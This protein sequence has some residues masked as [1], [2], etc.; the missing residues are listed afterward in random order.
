[1]NKLSRICFSVFALFLLSAGAFAQV[2]N[3]DS[4]TPKIQTNYDQGK[5][6][7]AVELR[8]L[9][10]DVDRAKQAYLSV[11]ITFKGKKARSKPV[12]VFFIV[13]VV[14]EGRKKFPEINRVGLRS[15]GKNVAEMVLLN[16]DQRMLS[17]TETLE[18][19]GTVIKIEIFKTLAA[20]KEELTFKVGETTF[21]IDPPTLARLVEYEKA[22]NQ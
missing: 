16:L 2:A 12:E 22:I 9:P 13:S 21:R 15:G 20:S 11:S 8:Q 18:T 14:S 19:L 4:K 6:E 17:Q 1:M 3:D 5:D 7:T 10:I